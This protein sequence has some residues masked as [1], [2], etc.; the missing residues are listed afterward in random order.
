MSREQAR[1]GNGR[2]KHIIGA[3]RLLTGSDAAPRVAMQG[4]SMRPLLRSPMVLELGPRD[5]PDRVGD[6]LVFERDGKLV[7]HRVTGMRG[8][9][10]QT[11]GDAIPWQPEYPTPE[12]VVGRVAA[13]YECDHPA[14]ARVDSRLFHMRGHWKAR[15]RG[16]RAL[17]HLAGATLFALLYPLYRIALRP[18]VHRA[19]SSWQ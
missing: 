10:L 12:S 16:L 5:V 9:R 18:L 1:A 6:I 8:G 19:R 2:A 4:R 11:C 15:L 13:V 14:A 7:A 3:V 17:P